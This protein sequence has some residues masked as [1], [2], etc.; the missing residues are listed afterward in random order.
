MQ[1]TELHLSR[2][3]QAALLRGLIAHESRAIAPIK[4]QRDWANKVADGASWSRSLLTLDVA[5]D[6]SDSLIAFQVRHHSLFT[7]FLHL[8]CPTMSAA[9]KA[10]LER[11]LYKG[12]I[13]SGT[14][15]LALLAPQ[16]VLTGFLVGELGSVL[17]ELPEIVAREHAQRLQRDLHRLQGRKGFYG[18]LLR[19][20]ENRATL[21]PA[22]VAELRRRSRS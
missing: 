20:V 1:H 5:G 22:L 15:A 7:R 3:A 2:E 18:H 6:A 21:E 19:A 12:A 11:G 9:D 14:W 17:L 16:F 8:H 4:K 10:A 13:K